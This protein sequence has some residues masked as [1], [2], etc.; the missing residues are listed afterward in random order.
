MDASDHH[1]N[2]R[3][4]NK[5]RPGHPEEGHKQCPSRMRVK[6][7]SSSMK[8][9]TR[10][11]RHIDRCDYSLQGVQLDRKNKK[12]ITPSSQTRL[13]NYDTRVKIN[14]RT[15]KHWQLHLWMHR[16]TIRTLGCQTKAGP[17][18]L[19]RGTSNARHAC[20]SSNARQ[21]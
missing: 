8:R 2:S 6:Q 1:K 3:L 15:W 5:G 7:C 10:K 21:A 19:K 20:L 14:I 17:A 12:T 11:R 9:G 16:T 13:S 18:V 4:P